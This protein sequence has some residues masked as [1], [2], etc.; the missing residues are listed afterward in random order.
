VNNWKTTAAGV[1]AAV[2]MAWANYSG[3][4]TWQGYLSCLG[5]VVIGALAKDW[6]TH[7]TETQVQVATVQAKDAAIAAVNK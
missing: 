7:S 1:L 4:N 3:A 6:N 2:A 5:P